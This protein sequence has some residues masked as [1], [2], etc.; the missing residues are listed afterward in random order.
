MSLKVL[1][2]LPQML[3][4]GALPAA[5]VEALYVHVPFCFHKCHY[6]DFYSI[7][8]QT[9]ERMSRFVELTLREAETWTRSAR[10]PA[11][12]PRTVFFGGGTPTLLPIDSM[13]RLLEGLRERIDLSDVGEFTVECNPATASLEYFQMLRTAGVDRISFGAQ[14]FDRHELKQLERHHDPDDVPK[15]LD[16]ARAAGFERINFDLIYAIPGQTLESWAASLD[17][18]IA[19]GTKHLSAYGLTYE[20]NTAITVRRRLGHFVAAEESLELDML[21]HARA[22]LAGA[23]L[24]PYEISNYAAPGEECRHN[25]VYWTGG[26]YVGL[27]PSAAS[28]VEG[29]RWRN[30]P[31]LGEWERAAAAGELPSIEVEQ[32]TPRRRAGELAMLQLRLSRGLNFAE[33][34]AR[35]GHD[36]R[37][38]WAD[39]IERFSAVG[40]LSADDRALRLTDRGVAVADALA[41]EFLDAPAN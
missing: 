18:A 12:R 2:D 41:A 4:P 13:R 16:L 19:L 34:A 3:D 29:W 33:F 25:L 22:R 37:Q 21:R 8:R 31:H 24:P 1:N 28:H 23:G 26:S 14:S 15:S 40:L 38:L 36:A 10:G 17:S 32:L 20:S 6:C 9:D 27:G 7:T 11:L 30:R 35:T 5:E 39:P